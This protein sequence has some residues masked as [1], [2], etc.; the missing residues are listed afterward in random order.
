MK[1][2]F[3]LIEKLK[4]IKKKGWIKTHRVGTTGV[5]KTLEDLLN[6]KENNIPGP[7]SEV[8][9]LKSARKNVSSMLTLFTKDPLPKKANSKILK[10]FGYSSQNNPRSKRL[11]TTVN[12]VS[13]NTIKSRKGLKIEI[14]GEK[15]NLISSNKEVLG[16]WDKKTL[17][18]CF[19]IKI[20]KLL[21][22][23][24]ETRRKGLNE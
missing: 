20:P 17:K 2:Y 7:N 15:I 23:K 12:A 24:A 1:G 16:Y 8:I 3:E 19:E 13:F 6:I 4:R 14:K 21:Y 18:N 11:E 5:G 10:K 9:E 22:V